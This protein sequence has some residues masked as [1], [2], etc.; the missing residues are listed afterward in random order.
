MEIDWLTVA[1]QIVNFLVLVWLLH[2]FLYGPIVRAMDRR[3]RRIAER[4]REAREKASEAENEARR[5]REKSAEVE[6]CRERALAEARG[7]AE[8][9]RR[10][11]QQEVRA[12]VERMREDW[13]AQLEDQREEFLSDVRRHAAEH[14]SRLARRALGD[15]ANAELEE[16]IA[17]VF[18]DRL[19]RLDKDAK[20]KIAEACRAEGEGL[21]V[22]SAFDVS[23][24]LRRRIT[25]AVHEAI[26]KVEVR[27]ERSLEMA[28]GLELRAGGQAVVWSL[29]GYLDS[30]ESRL[31]TELAELAPKRAPASAE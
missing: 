2:R 25:K 26:G 22:H 5:Y 24:D 13:R 19:E 27:Y 31:D 15:L 12:E 3:E 9:L 8:A 28:C 7:E 11:L 20:H 17:E 21:I 23:P 10:S 4:L 16:Q 6:Q 30:L 14:F 1:A 18:V 29:D